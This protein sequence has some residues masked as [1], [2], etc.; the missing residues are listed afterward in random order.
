[1]SAALAPRRRTE[2]G[3][4]VI[5]AIVI[6]SA[7]VLAGFGRNAAVPGDVFAFL[8]VMCAMFG[9][10]HFAVRR[11]APN[12]DPLMVP[13]AMMLNGIGYVFIARLNP[14]LASQQAVWTAVGILGF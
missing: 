1:M 14:H 6:G 12:A 13:L 5:A 8:A 11:L 7:H 2:A 10:V 9:V 4:L 3:L